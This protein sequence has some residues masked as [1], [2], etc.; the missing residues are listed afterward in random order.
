[1]IDVKEATQRALG[2]FGELFPNGYQNLR[3]EEIEIS[4]D[5][6]YWYVTLGFDVPPGPSVAGLAQAL[7]GKAERAYKVFKIDAANGKFVSVKIR[8]V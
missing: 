8:E 4:D 2:Y 3:L 7:T 6:R 5:D 1:M